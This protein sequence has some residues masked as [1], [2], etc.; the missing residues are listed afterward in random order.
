MTKKIYDLTVK[1]GEYTD[2]SGQT[3]G[4]Y[5]NVGAMMERDDGGRYLF[6]D[7]T[8]NFAGFPNPDNRDNVLVSMF[9]IRDNSKP[10]NTQASQGT[11]NKGEEDIPF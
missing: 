4:R 8:I 10:T 3:K 6:I 2:H 5:V 7:R 9:E 11:G 1:T